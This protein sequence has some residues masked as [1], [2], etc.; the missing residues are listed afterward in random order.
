MPD[1]DKHGDILE[2]GKFTLDKDGNKIPDPTAP[3]NPTQ[4]IEIRRLNALKTAAN[5]Q[6]GQTVEIV[7]PPP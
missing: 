5:A 4:V 3:E 7:D 6:A 2:G 1:R